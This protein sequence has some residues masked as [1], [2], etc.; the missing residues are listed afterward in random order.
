MKEIV[1]ILTNECMPGLVKIGR[2][3]TSVEQRMRELYTTS[4]P[5]PFHCHY[6]AIVENGKLVEDKLHYAFGDQRVPTNREFFR[7]DP[8]RV[9]A[10]LELVSLQEVTPEVVSDM[11]QELKEFS[12]R[13]PPFRFSIAGVPIG[14]ELHFVRNEE[15]TCKVIDDR[16]VEF[17]EKPTSLS[18]AA[19]E[20][21]QELGWRSSQVQGPIYWLYEGESLEERRQR[22]ETQG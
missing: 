13:R 7:I 18:A 1:Y 17:R 4:V 9:R 2:T 6:A 20:L 12:E 19:S 14:A 16:S 5:Y 8:N 21:L 15:I 11:T 10:V 22:I 3:N